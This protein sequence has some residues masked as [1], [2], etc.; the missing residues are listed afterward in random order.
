MKTTIFLALVVGL[1]FGVA[2]NNAATQ[3]AK[4]QVYAVCN[5]ARLEISG[6]SEQA[7]GDL[8]DRLGVEFL[9]DSNNSLTS[10]HCWTEAK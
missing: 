8:Q 3:N 7:C 6:A 2:I 5:G 1:M 4:R 9:C 10:N